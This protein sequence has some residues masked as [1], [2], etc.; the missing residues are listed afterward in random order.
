MEDREIV[1]VA[2]SN[3]YNEFK[4]YLENVHFN[5]DM[6]E[7]NNIYLKSSKNKTYYVLTDSGKS[8]ELESVLTKKM[9][10]NN[11]EHFDYYYSKCLKDLTDEEKTDFTKFINKLSSKDAINTVKTVLVN[12]KDK[13]EKSP[14]WLN[15]N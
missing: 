14:E 7:N 5:S 3:D 6:P 4:K 13:L 1:D 9:L 15:K 12:S 10:E 8:I 2:I 11:K